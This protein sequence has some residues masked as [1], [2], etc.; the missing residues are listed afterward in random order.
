VNSSPLVVAGAAD[1]LGNFADQPEK[2]RKEIVSEL[3][4]GYA[5][6]ASAA[7]NAAA[8]NKDKALAK[9]R[10]AV[11]EGAFKESLKKLTGEDHP[12]APA[13][14]KWYNDNKSKKWG[15]LTAGE[16]GWP[17]PGPR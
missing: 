1:G 5:T 6:F 9:E 8:P 14:Q 13:W 10:L 12:D 15:E 2:A 11:V 16:G 7:S 3:V 4:K 17:A